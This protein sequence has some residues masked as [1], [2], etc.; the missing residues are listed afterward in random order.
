LAQEIAEALQW[1]AVVRQ[2]IEEG[3]AEGKWIPREDVDGLLANRPEAGLLD[4]IQ[5]AG[6]EPLLDSDE[7]NAAQD[8]HSDLRTRIALVNEEITGAEL[9]MRQGFFEAI[10]KSPLTEEQAR[11]VICLDNRV[12]V[13][14]AAGSGKTSVMVARAAYV[15]SRGF[16]QADRILLLAFNKA[17]AV[18]LRERVETRF[19]KAGIASAGVRASTFHAL[20]L[21]VIG[22]ATG[23]M[24]RLAPWIDRGDDGRMILSIVDELRDK[25]EHFKYRWD[26][27]RT[28]FANAPL[29]FNEAEPD[30][31]DR[32]NKATGFRTFSGELVRSHGERLIANFLFLN[33][34]R[35]D[36]ERP[37]HVD[38]ADALHPQYRPDFY[39]PDVDVWHEHWALDKEG[40]APTGFT[41]YHEAM[42]WKRNVHALY[43]ST[44]VES[45]WADVMLGN[46]L[47]ELQKDLTA[48]GLTFDWNPDRPI[49]SA[50]PMGHEH[51]AR[52][53]RTFMTH[54][55]S[56]ALTP[57]DIDE[58]LRSDLARLDGSRTRLFLDLYWQVH[59]EWQKRLEQEASIDFEDMLIQAAGH[60]E[61][62]EVDLGF[63]M[64]LVDEFQDASRAR[65]RL[66]SGLLRSPGRFLLAVGDDWQS[67]N[68]F[69]GADVS[70][71]TDFA[72]W[73]GSGPR[74]AL[75]TTFRCPQPI[76]DVA[77]SFVS[78]N[79]N[80]IKKTM[81][82]VQDPISPAVTV[83]RAE[84]AEEAVA[85]FLA[86]L[87]ADVSHGT[88]QAGPD[89]RVS[90][91]ILGR[92]RFQQ[93]LVPHRP[94][95]NLDVR[96]RTVHGAK[97]LEADYIVI[98]GMTTGTNGFPST[99]ADDPILALA[100]P[101][102]EEFPH[103]EE[104]RL[105]YV[106]L[107]RARRQ[108]TI[109]TSKNNISPF[110]LELLG[111]SEV[112]VPDEGEGSIK[113]CPSCGRG[114]LLPRTGRHGAFLGCSR[115]PGCEYTRNGR[116]H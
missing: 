103:A 50:K 47:S 32:A 24:C 82:S 13:L 65:A 11:A 99:I 110:V 61:R 6:I 92:Y 38:L 96:F 93:D 59:A 95:E 86:G 7:L 94:P 16:V 48:V 91:D 58:R 54:V 33:G 69:A 55:K 111:S 57:D 36:Y 87:S 18:E 42:A 10:E 71:T 52:F 109:I 105:F 29:G 113:V 22:Q 68:R 19:A 17:A 89:G 27:F 23:K 4:R 63:E 80:Q 107:T 9:R 64:I 21:K 53:M 77:T 106:A 45:T 26:L 101:T 74:L 83:I 114:H 72:S 5:K 98:P 78:K 73:F 20:G 84:D 51:L 56:N 25:S 46:G 28:L 70:V 31:Y 60:L 34:I 1:R 108:V 41:G 3:L 37:Y 102:P 97:G 75:T 116:S 67:I 2:R 40:R 62:G 81:R 112:F 88:V 104:R 39:Y 115:F 79:P 49:E 85:A 43:G 30:G 44:L 35:Y 100:M 14:A 12:Q 90:V 15:A 76:C 66:V 8:L